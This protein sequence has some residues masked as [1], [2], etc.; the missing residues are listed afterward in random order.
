MLFLIVTPKLYPKL[1]D[2]CFKLIGDREFN[3]LTDHMNNET[4]QQ[5]LNALHEFFNGEIIEN[6]LGWP[7]Y[8]TWDEAERAEQYPYAVYESE[9]HNFFVKLNDN[10][11]KIE[12]SP[13]TNDDH[14]FMVARAIGEEYGK[15]HLHHNKD[16][17]KAWFECDGEER[18]VSLQGDGR[19]A[20]CVRQ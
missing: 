19:Y 14:T 4:L 9:T 16:R 5:K 17:W 2:I 8:Y 6:V 13:R 7:I 12:F 15:F 1:L 20:V 11:E 18:S 3:H 10:S